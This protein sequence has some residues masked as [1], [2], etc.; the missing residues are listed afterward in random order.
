MYSGLSDLKTLITQLNATQQA[1]L[2]ESIFAGERKATPDVD[3]A[4]PVVRTI[5]ILLAMSTL[6]VTTRLAVKYR[7]TRRL[8][9]DDGFMAIALV[10]CNA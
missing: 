10:S 9:L 6:V 5:W 3:L 2:L 7:T 8:Y 4:P 1:N